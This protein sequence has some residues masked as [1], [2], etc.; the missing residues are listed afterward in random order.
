[1]KKYKHLFLSVFIIIIDQLSKIFIINN[2]KLNTIGY[3][4]FNDFLQI[5]HV[6]NNAVAFSLGNTLSLPV[7]TILFIIIPIIVLF[8]VF[9]LMYYEKEITISPFQRWLLAGFIG[10]GVGNLIDRIFRDFQVVDFMSN[11]VFGLFGLE[12]WPTWNFADASIV[13]CG[14]LMLISIIYGYFNNKKI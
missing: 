14:V 1:M 12:R 2:I 11:K 9:Y 4:F 10:G 13:I 8:Y 6:R 5:I 7:R 3:S